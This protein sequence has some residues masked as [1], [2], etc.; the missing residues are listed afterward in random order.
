MN[1]G[2]LYHPR[3]PVH[4]GEL[5]DLIK[6]SGA[7]AWL[8]QEKIDDLEFRVID[9]EWV[10]GFPKS[11]WPQGRV[12][13]LQAEIRWWTFDGDRYD[14]LLL[15]EKKI[16]LSREIWDETKMEISKQYSIYLWGER[17]S[18]DKYWIETRIPRPLC[19]PIDEN[20]WQKRKSEYAAIKACDYSNNGVVQLTRFLALELV[21]KPHG[22][23]HD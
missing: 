2:Y 14:I 18:N 1:C 10:D 3:A 6:K 4:L 17:K 21:D 20:E 16:E 15:S 23:I 5:L 22:G 7:P 13:G 8:I 9:N 11:L 12:F 19:Y